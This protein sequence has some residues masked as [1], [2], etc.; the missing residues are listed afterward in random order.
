MSRMQ[1]LKFNVDPVLT[2]L[3]QGY[4]NNELIG[5]ALFPEAFVQKESGKIPLFG[6][7]SFSIYST[8]RGLRA[9]SNTIPVE[10]L[11]TDNYLLT[12]H[13]L[14]A[15][16]DYREDAEAMNADLMRAY[17][18]KQVVDGINLKQEKMIA[19]IVRN[20]SN[21]A[22]G[23]AKALSTTSC[24]SDYVN[25]NPIQDIEEAKEA[26]RSQT[27]KYPNVMVLGAV[28]YSLIKFHP[29]ITDVIEYTKKSVATPQILSE[30]FDIPT[31]KVGLAT[32]L[33][34]NGLFIDLWGDDVI[35]AYVPQLPKTEQNI[36]EPAFGYTLVKEGTPRVDSYVA[37]GGKIE[38]IR[39]TKIF[40]VKQTSQI[41]GYLIANTKA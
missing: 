18:T 32:Y 9:K 37:E 4:S 35:L 13:D 23:N 19:D 33:G 24:W 3:A 40:Q 22:S 17:R 41:A 2:E 8:E 29:R 30:I 34:S 1:E 16:V 11:N 15:P 14:Q 26:I 25:S 31:M 38:L 10:S 6:K 5:T 36:F 27:G 39:N 21:Y 12:E 7:E 28:S 20:A